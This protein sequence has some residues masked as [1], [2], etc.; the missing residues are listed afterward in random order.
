MQ[1]AALAFLSDSVVVLQN[2]A[3]KGGGVNVDGGSTLVV[4]GAARV[5]NNSA[6]LGACIAIA[7]AGNV[8][9]REHATIQECAVDQDGGAVYL[10]SANLHLSDASLIANCTATE[11]G[12]G[13]FAAGPSTITIQDAARVVNAAANTRGGA[14]F[15]ISFHKTG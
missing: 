3:H 7:D 13:V 8:E 5:S 12:G 14:V 1:S 15:A 2:R 10:Q 11:R 4:A 6:V 9:L